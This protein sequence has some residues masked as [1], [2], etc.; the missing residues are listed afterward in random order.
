MMT[1]A[2]AVAALAAIRPIAM[3][4]A[5]SA[6]CREA[7]ILAAVLGGNGLARQP[8]DVA[9]LITLLSI[10]QR[11]GTAGCARARGAADTVH[12]ALGHIG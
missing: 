4:T 12:V 9:K 7:S 2:A 1:L 5:S 8:L 6:I 10:H 3:R 11:D